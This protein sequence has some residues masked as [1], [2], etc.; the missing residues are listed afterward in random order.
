MTANPLRRD[1]ADREHLARLLP[2]P[3]ERDLPGGRATVY[4]EFLM[5]QIDEPDTT[6]AADPDRSTRPRWRARRLVPAGALAVA[7]AAAVT[8]G[9]AL[10]GNQA[11]S[12]AWA[13]EDGPSDNLTV[14]IYEFTDAAGLEARLREDGI[15][16]VVDYI[17]AD[18]GCSY[19]GQLLLSPEEV[20]KI[21]AGM[22]LPAPGEAAD[23]ESADEDVAIPI[24]RALLPAD[25]TLSIFAIVLPGQTKPAMFRFG[26]LQGEVGHCD[27][28]RG[29]PLLDGGPV[30]P[31]AV[32]PSAQLSAPP[33]T[34]LSAPPA[35]RLSAPPATAAP[36]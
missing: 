27:A 29:G 21:V 5:H 3:V 25:H 16:A 7:V 28:D 10:V 14:H 31:G 26:Y 4:R 8:F 32:V 1:P 35:T 9:P 19:G 22:P 24:E 6:P 20:G 17:H 15:R 2:A 12:P 33:T 23:V 13:V 18:E 34:R 36:R 30:G 11:A